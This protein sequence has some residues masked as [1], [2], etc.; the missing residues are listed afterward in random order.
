[1][2]SNVRLLLRANAQVAALDCNGLTPLAYAVNGHA[3]STVR[4]LLHAKSSLN[5]AFAAAAFHRVHQVRRS[6]F[7]GSPLH[8]AVL[9]GAAAV[10][11]VLLHAKADAD[12][13]DSAG[14]TPYDY[15]ADYCAEM[16]DAL[17]R[18]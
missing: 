13:V 5:G 16:V 8:L 10:V 1:L 14:W 3:P 2:D 15:A 9:L 18:R 7:V 17:R 6:G 12:A 4:L 11:R